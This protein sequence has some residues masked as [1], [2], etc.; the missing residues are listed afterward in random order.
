MEGKGVDYPKREGSNLT[1][2][3]AARVSPPPVKGQPDMFKGMAD[4]VE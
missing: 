1:F 4:A 2:S 3:K